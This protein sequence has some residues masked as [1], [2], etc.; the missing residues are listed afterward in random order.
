VA[1]LLV[2]AV[3]MPLIG[4]VPASAALFIVAARL[5]GSRR[6][7]RDAIVGLA[8]ATLLFVAFTQG[9][10]LDLPRDPLTR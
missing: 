6:A 5:L 9:L 7:V 3:A 4:F 1:A 2:Y 10:G 8:A